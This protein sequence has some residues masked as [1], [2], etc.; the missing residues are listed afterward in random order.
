MLA[1]SDFANDRKDAGDIGAGHN[2]T[3]LYE[4]ALAGDSTVSETANEPLRYQKNAMAEK[5]VAAKPEGDFAGEILTLSLRYKKPDEN[6]SKKIEFTLDD[7]P[8]SFSGTSQDLQF[9]A[10]VASFGMLLRNSQH[11]GS[12]SFDWVEATASRAIGNDITGRRIEFLD[13]VRKAK[14]LQFIDVERKTK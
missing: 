5:Q 10:A 1:A 8:T 9:S 12:T 3:A 7:E 6:V 14:S 13:L 2:V 11:R 4:L